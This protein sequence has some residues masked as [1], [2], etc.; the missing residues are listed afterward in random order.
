MWGVLGVIGIFVIGFAISFFVARHQIARSVAAH[1]AGLNAG[2]KDLENFDPQGAE[3][4][5]SALGIASS[6][7]EGWIG[8]IGSLFRGGSGALASFQDISRQLV[9][10]PQEYEALQADVFATANPSSTVNG[11][12]NFS[13]DLDALRGTVDALDDD[14]DQMP[15]GAMSFGGTAALGGENYIALKSELHGLRQF[16]DKFAPWFT[17]G[18]P[19]HVLVLFENSAELRPGGGFLGSYADLA[20]ANGTIA[21]V[22]VHDVADVDAGF[23]E[24]IIPPKALQPEISRFRPADTNWFF[25]FPTSASKTLAYFEAS[26]LYSGIGNAGDTTNKSNTSHSSNSTNGT[27]GTN[28]TNS[29]D[30]TNPTDFDGV[31]AITPAVISDLLAATGPVTISVSSTVSRSLAA[32]TPTTFTS[33]TALV[34]IQKLV[35]DGQAQ[36]A[37]YPK[38]VLRSLADAI[39]VQLAS[40]TDVE[41]QGL[42]SMALGWVNDK[43]AMAYFKDPEFEDFL[44]AY[45]AAGDVYQMP[46]DFNGDYLAVVDAN[47]NG[48]KSDLYVSSTVAWQSQINAD[49]TID[50]NVIIDRAHHG[51]ASPYWWYQVTNQDYL[52]L[53]VP[54][55][56]VL[57]NESGGAV[58]KITPK[59][60]YAKLG[61]AVDSTIADIESST[62][63]LFGYPA[64]TTHEEDGKGV[65]AAWVT[66]K[67]G[68]SSEVSLEYSHHAFSVP[69]SGVSYQFVFEKQPSTARHYS[70]NFYAPPG[71]QF[72]ENNLPS[73]RYESDAPPGR[74]I[75]TLT[76]DKI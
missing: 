36:S 55:G 48:G 54:D 44:A 31:I 53:F 30:T 65:F 27:N 74:L 59:V 33:S 6:G 43:D 70:F 76:L 64:V 35:Q 7:T 40:S 2:V 75:I 15:A 58:K 4:E 34:Q 66:T 19:H 49:G 67:A 29:T 1:S 8:T 28:M 26:S 71:Y 72:A 39:F 62:R 46:Q 18:T 47:I 69:A 10:L 50:D 13:R 11:T 9:L 23:S 24:N 51:N 37:T 56:S 3:Q 22:A 16:L 52:Q 60:D 12:N 14:T 20:I 17:T 5:F 63:P 57:A 61:Y 42:I 25:D 45:G 21:D 73:Y 68:A 32:T 41:R 38:A